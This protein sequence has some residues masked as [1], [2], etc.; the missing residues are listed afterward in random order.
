M[1]APIKT[2]QPRALR[3]QFMERIMHASQATSAQT[4]ISDLPK[5]LA[6]EELRK[7][8][9]YGRAVHYL[10]GEQIY[11]YDNP[12]IRKHLA[13]AHVKPLVVGH[14]GKTPEQN[15]I[16]VHLNRVIKKHDLNMLCRGAWPWRPGIGAGQ[17]DRHKIY[18]DEHGEDMPEVRNW[19]WKPRTATTPS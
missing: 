2:A 16:Y 11:L 19:K 4:Q 10:S 17:A 1:P 3:G 5:V 13:L 9:T 7:M 12:M 15:F 8:N 6:S 14:S 18:I